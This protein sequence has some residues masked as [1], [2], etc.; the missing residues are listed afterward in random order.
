MELPHTDV[1]TWLRSEMINI[2]EEVEVLEV[3]LCWTEFNVRDRLDN[4]KDLLECVRFPLINHT[5]MQDLFSQHVKNRCVVQSVRTYL[6]TCDILSDDIRSFPRKSSTRSIYVIGGFYRPAN[7]RWSDAIS[8]K[9]V[10]KFDLYNNT[11]ENVPSLSYPRNK[12]GAVSLNR[13]IYVV[14]GEDDSLML[15]SLEIFDPQAEC[16]SEGAPLNYA[17]CGFGL[18]TCDGKV[19]AL[20]GWIGA[21]LGDTIEMYDPSL[22]SWVIW[23]TIPRPRFSCGVTEMEGML[24]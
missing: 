17:R 24:L 23:A 2:A 22:D 5:Q 4:L 20:G 8:V 12:H 15:N 14:G 11:W 18:C 21:F 13:K 3:A 16:W 7:G 1:M 10:H 9:N 19:Y 6:R